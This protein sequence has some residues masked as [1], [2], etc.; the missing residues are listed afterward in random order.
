MKEK[1][2]LH[3]LEMRAETFARQ[4]GPLYQ[5]AVANLNPRVLR[6]SGGSSAT[7]GSRYPRGIIGDEIASDI[8]PCNKQWW[9]SRPS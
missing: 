4:V 1:S 8:P 9:S 3:Q 5:A 6:R 7:H 2:R